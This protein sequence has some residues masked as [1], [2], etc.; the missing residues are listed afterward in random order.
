MAKTKVEAV[1]YVRVSSTNQVEGNGLAR[2][3]KNIAA[4]SR[5]RYDILT[6]YRET[7]VSGTV[8]E[9]PA[10]LAM[11]ADLTQNGR[12]KVIL[13]ESADRLGRS[14]EVSLSIL[15]ECRKHGIQ[16]IAADSGSNLT[17]DQDPMA[18]AMALVQGVFAQ[19]DRR[20]LV[21][22][23]RTARRAKREATGR[24]EGRLPYGS[25]EGEKAGLA[26]IETMSRRYGFADIAAALTTAG[27]PTRTGKPWTRQSVAVIIKRLKANRKKGRDQSVA[28]D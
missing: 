28:A 21:L 27:H 24:C 25:R 19:L 1:A 11:L 22:K 17:D 4:Y 3:E 23:L 14:L 26:M 9:R 12:P 2:Q 5:G 13:V 15:S 20:R 8:A 18:E 7:G 10:L 16:I 6:L